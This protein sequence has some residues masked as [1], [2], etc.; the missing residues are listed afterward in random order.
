MAGRTFFHARPRG[1]NTPAVLLLDELY[2]KGVVSPF[3]AWLDRSSTLSSL[4]CDVE[5]ARISFAKRG[6]RP[7]CFR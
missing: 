6:V 7:F 1:G 5:R 3:R 4:A 2:W